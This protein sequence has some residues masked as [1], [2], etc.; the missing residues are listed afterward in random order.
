SD[1]EDH[2][3]ATAVAWLLKQAEA[4]RAL[5]LVRVHTVLAEDPDGADAL[6]LVLS[7]LQATL[8][9]LIQAD[10]QGFYVRAADPRRDDAAERLIAKL[11]AELGELNQATIDEVFEGD[12]T[13]WQITW[14]PDMDRLGV[15]GWR[16]MAV[17]DGDEWILFE[18]DAGNPAHREAFCRG[19]VPVGV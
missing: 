8:G 18:M 6:D 17:V 2:Q 4:V 15:T 10:Y 7:H 14:D 1:A 3:P 11:R 19:E 5:Y 16:R 13:D 9:G 12:P